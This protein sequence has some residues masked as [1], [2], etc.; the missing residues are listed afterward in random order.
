LNCAY[1]LSLETLLNEKVLTGIPS[2]L[3]S[4]KSFTDGSVA[5]KRTAYYYFPAGKET[6]I[7]VIMNKIVGGGDS[8]LSFFVN[9]EADYSKWTYPTL[10]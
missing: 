7:V 2:Y 1:K 9:P 3:K 8:A 6:E 10:Q 4:D 5:Y